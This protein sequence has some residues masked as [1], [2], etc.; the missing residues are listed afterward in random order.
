MDNS[1]FTFGDIVS[2]TIRVNNNGNASCSAD[3]T[4][5]VVIQ[6]GR[7]TGLQNGTAVMKDHANAVCTFSQNSSGLLNANFNGFNSV[8]EQT[9]AHHEIYNF[10]S[11]VKASTPEISVSND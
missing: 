10:I 5:E 7:V 2:A 9:Q 6:S 1:I 4:A 11:A 8:E 3:I